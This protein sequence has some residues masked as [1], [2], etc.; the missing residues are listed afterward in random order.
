MLCSFFWV[1]P[2]RLNFMC[3]RFGTLCHLH[4][5]RWC[6]QEDFFLLTPPTRTK[7]ELTECS[8]PSAN[9]IK[10]L[11]NHPKQRK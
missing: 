7:I 9:K 2:W 4:L 11:W 3:R 1:I 8:E 10:T 6:I 5:H